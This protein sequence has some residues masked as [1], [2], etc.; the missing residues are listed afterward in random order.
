MFRWKR[1]ESGD[2]IK[3]DGRPM[4]QFIAIERSDSGEWA[5]PGVSEIIVFSQMVRELSMYVIYPR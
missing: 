1:T 2:V 5:I 4:L 3:K